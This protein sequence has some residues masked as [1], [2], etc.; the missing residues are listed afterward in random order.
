[1]ARNPSSAI[2]AID[3]FHQPHLTMANEV[4]ETQDLGNTMAANSLVFDVARACV[5]PKSLVIFSLISWTLDFT[6]LCLSQYGYLVVSG[7]CEFDYN[8]S[9]YLSNSIVI[10]IDRYEY[11]N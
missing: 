11:C 8:K 7:H 1:L 4:A 10:S 5:A 6:W 9:T 3:Q 2:D